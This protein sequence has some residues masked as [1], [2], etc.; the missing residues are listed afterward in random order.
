VILDIMGASYFADNLATLARDGRLLLIGFMGG[1]TVEQVNLQ[2]IMTKRAVITGSAMR[3]RTTHEKAAIASALKQHVWPVLEQGRCLP[4]IHA[5]YPLARAADAH[6]DMESRQ[7]I[8]KIV[9]EV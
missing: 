1:T 8:G 3:P 5:T 2:A 4:L 9:L 6:R 7:H